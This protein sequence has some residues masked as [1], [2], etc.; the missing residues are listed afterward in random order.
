MRAPVL[1][2]PCAGIIGLWQVARWPVIPLS[3]VAVEGMPTVLRPVRPVRAAAHPGWPR[4]R[5]QVWVYSP[6]H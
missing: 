3:M 5:G 1:P 4:A 2:T 6:P